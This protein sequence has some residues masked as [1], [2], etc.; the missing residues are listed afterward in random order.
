M[1]KVCGVPASASSILG[2]LGA[3]LALAACSAL[4]AVPPGSTGLPFLSCSV[5]PGSCMFDSRLQTPFLAADRLELISLLFFPSVLLHIS[6]REWSEPL[7]GTQVSS[8]NLSCCCVQGAFK[9]VSVGEREGEGCLLFPH[10]PLC[11]L[12][13]PQAIAEPDEPW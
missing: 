5:F 11:V 8:G 9:G 4:L 6:V 1:G 12:V 13:P 10:V 2:P 3:V 7:A